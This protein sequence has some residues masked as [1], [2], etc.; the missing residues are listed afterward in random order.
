MRKTKQVKIEG[1]DQE[2]TVKEL[3]MKDIQAVIKELTALK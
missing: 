3:R 2:V 1:M